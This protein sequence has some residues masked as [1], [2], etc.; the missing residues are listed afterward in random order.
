MTTSRTLTDRY[1]EATLRRVP[2][3]QR[4]DI[5][6]ELRASIADAV[7]DHLAAGSDPAE[8][9]LAVLTEL[10]DPARLAAGYADRPLH[11]IGPGL[12]LDYVRVLTALLATVV[13]AVAAVVGLMRGLHGAPAPSV[14]GDTLRA[15]LTA[16]LHIAFWTTLVFMI[17]ERTAASRGTPARPWTP[18]ALPD[19]PPSRRARYG[20]LI[21]LTVVTVLFTT[22]ILL[23]P[24]VSTETDADGDA[25]GLF[26]P[27][28]WE[29]G[30]VHLFIALVIASL[31]FAY[32][33]HHVRWSVP[34]AVAG[35]LVDL[36][37]PLMLIWLAANDRLLNPAFVQATGWPPSVPRWI[38]TGLVV[39]SI[40]TLVHTVLD[41]LARARR[42]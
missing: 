33:R 31:A 23:S 12:Y 6:R 22:F 7:D 36:A 26:S 35:S 20:E 11:L 38:T 1:V 13:P 27:R 10:G 17:I 32:A 42:R 39:L 29:T 25:I 34:F 21:A 19:P 14:A 3:R 40:G 37:C 9:E 15:A 8:A 28:L 16:G 2:G 5:E 4:P 24:V 30:E 18:A 41:G